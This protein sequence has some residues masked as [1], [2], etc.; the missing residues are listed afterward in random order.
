MDPTA[1]DS[2]FN[3]DVGLD[4]E[5]EEEEDLMTPRQQLMKYSEVVVAMTGELLKCFRGESSGRG[6]AIIGGRGGGSA[7]PAGPLDPMHTRLA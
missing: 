7:C 6:R 2:P 4:I 1:S 3:L 5:I